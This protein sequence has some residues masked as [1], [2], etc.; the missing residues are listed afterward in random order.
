MFEGIRRGSGLTKKAWAV[1]RSDPASRQTPADR[2]RP[3][4]RRL[5]RARRPR[6]AAGRQ[7]QYR[8]RH[9][10]Q[11]AAS[12][13]GV[14][15]GV[16]SVPTSTSPSPPPQI[17][18]CGAWNRT[19]PRPG[20]SLVAASGRPPPGRWCRSGCRWCSIRCADGAAAPTT[21]RPM[22]VRNLEAGHVPRRAGPGFRGLGAVPGHETLGDD[23][24]PAL[25]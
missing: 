5:C 16:H 4:P 8:G 23:V 19:W 17:R 15:G 10:R 24:P 14:P 2:W 3:R 11:R 9:R 25:G 13:G 1:I 18:P 22:S 7:R 21:S 6:R 12:D 20:A